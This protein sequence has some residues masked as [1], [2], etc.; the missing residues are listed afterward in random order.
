MRTGK[1]HLEKRIKLKKKDIFKVK[2][3][4]LEYLKPL[5][6]DVVVAGS[7]RRG[8]DTPGDIDFLVIPNKKWDT[9]KLPYDEMLW[10]GNKKIGIFFAGVHID[11]MITD[12]KSWGAALLHFTGSQKFNIMMRMRAITRKMKLN[13]YG[14]FA[15]D[16]TFI[17]SRQ[18]VQ[19]FAMLGLKNIP[20]E[21]R[22]DKVNFSDWVLAPAKLSIDRRIRA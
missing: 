4:Y 20:A 8:V 7:I 1:V 3:K 15:E 2:D 22:T 10:S 6:K 9:R 5:C 11:I 12:E 13:E 17:A 18:E 21:S 14:L 19:I 16:G